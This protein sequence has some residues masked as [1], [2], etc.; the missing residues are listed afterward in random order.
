MVRDRRY[1]RTALRAPPTTRAH[2]IPGGGSAAGLPSRRVRR[3]PLPAGGCFIPRLIV[4]ASY[5]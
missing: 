4:L 5:L 1:R 3:R 2:T